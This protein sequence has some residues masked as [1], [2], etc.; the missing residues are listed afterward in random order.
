MI[1]Y[2][3]C[4]KA[5]QAVRLNIEM[6]ISITIEIKIESQGEGAYKFLETIIQ[7][8]DNSSRLLNID[9]VILWSPGTVAVDPVVPIGI[10]FASNPADNRNGIG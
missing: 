4:I 9:P 7:S 3:P 8:G 2:L 10:G 6:F 5:D 1:A